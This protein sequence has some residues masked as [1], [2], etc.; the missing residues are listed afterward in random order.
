MQLK[1][2]FQFVWKQ[3]RVALQKVRRPLALG[4]LAD[5]IRALDS[6]PGKHPAATVQ[7]AI[8]RTLIEPSLAK[9][10]EVDTFM[11]WAKGL[12]ITMLYH[13]CT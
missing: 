7:N 5:G 3:A 2:T 12:E 10:K 6:N 4:E 8:R 9:R 11:V 13:S 1:D